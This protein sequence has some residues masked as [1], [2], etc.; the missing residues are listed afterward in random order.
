MW[1]LLSFGGY[2]PQT[3]YFYDNRTPLRIRSLELLCIG[4][5]LTQIGTVTA[6]LGNGRSWKSDDLFPRKAAACAT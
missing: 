3:P 6:K 2:R 1:E 4:K 5:T